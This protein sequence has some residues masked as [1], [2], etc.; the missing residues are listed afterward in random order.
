MPP[1]EIIM[2]KISAPFLA[3]DV[4]QLE[5]LFQVSIECVEAVIFDREDLEDE[6]WNVVW[7]NIELARKN[8]SPRI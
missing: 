4:R 8:M 5:T 7:S 3:L 6:S 1:R 2:D